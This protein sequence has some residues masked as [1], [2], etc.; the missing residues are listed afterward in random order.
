MRTRL[1]ALVCLAAALVAFVGAAVLMLD[2]ISVDLSS[3]GVKEVASGGGFGCVVAPWD[4]GVNGDASEP[5]GEWTPALREEVAAKCYEANL[6][7]YNTGRGV[8]ALGVVL[9][10]VAVVVG[11]RGR[12][13]PAR[14]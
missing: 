12:S 6:A 13:R 11:V 4:A 5:G 7:R 1:L 9:L 8:A 3:T 14:A 2:N 10:G